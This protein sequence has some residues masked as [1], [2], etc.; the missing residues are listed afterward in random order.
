MSKVIGFIFSLVQYTHQ[1]PGC[2]QTTNQ[3]KRIHRFIIVCIN[4][5]QMFFR[6]FRESLALNTGIKSRSLNLKNVFLKVY[7]C[8]ILFVP[9]RWPMTIQNIEHALMP[10]KQLMTLGEL[11][12]ETSKSKVSNLLACPTR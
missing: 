2:Q 1:V 7:L 4:E 6:K 8:K 9:Y 11:I 12:S 3:E 10:F 5:I